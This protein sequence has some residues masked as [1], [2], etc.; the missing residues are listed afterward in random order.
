[1]KG[2]FFVVGP[3]AAGKSEIAAEVAFRYGAEVVSADAFQIYQG[4]DLLTAKPNAPTLAKARHH[5]IGTLPLSE[6]WNAAKFRSAALQAI[7]EIH[8]RDKPVIVAGGS[9]LYIKAL[10]HGLAS[11]PAPNAELREALNKW[12]VDQ[13]Y[14]RLQVLDPET[15]AT[16]DRKNQRRLAR[17]LEIC[18]LTG[19]PASI[20]RTQWKN[21]ETIAVTAGPT[22]ISA[23]A[24]VFVFR[25]R[26]DLFEQID[27]RVH[28][29][30]QR[31]VVD[32]VRAPLG[33]VGVTAA[34]TLG[35]RQIQQLVAGQ[36]SEPEAIASIQQ[37]TRQ[38][39]KRQL[40]WFR[41]QTNFEPLNLSLQSLDEAV[42]SILRKARSA[43]AQKNV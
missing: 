2:V 30:F 41:R 39:A 9:G 35:L 28:A 3:T 20:K 12:S 7:A 26:A 40:T 36:I 37:A 6:E 43:F 13:L 22:K 32:E 29:I 21:E 18:F 23:T 4:L 1:M 42:E 8:A 31:G 11:L 15:A 10:T 19:S 38:Y 33:K 34:K 5:L 25:D 27:R 24:G 14:S 17:A 16:I